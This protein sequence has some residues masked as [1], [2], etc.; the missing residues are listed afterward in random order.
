MPDALQT[1]KWWLTVIQEEA[2]AS[3]YMEERTSS[4]APTPSPLDPA[5]IYHLATTGLEQVSK[6]EES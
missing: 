5:T 4:H 2:I 1:A 6:E 3:V